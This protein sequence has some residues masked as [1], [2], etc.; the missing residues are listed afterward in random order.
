MNRPAYT[1][2]ANVQELLQQ[3]KP[4]QT[5]VVTAGMPYANGPLHL[6]HLA[7]AHVPADILARYMRMMIGKENV[8]YVCGT[9]DHGSTSEVAALKN[10][11]TVRE[12][13]DSIHT[14]QKATMDRYGISLN[15]YSGTSRPEWFPVHSELCQEFI[16]KLYHNGMLEKKR[17]NQ[18][19]NESEKPASKAGFFNAQIP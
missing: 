13:I 19:S 7:G 17:I 16:R 8:L 9:D 15:V 5:V 12:F 10:N 4:P 11:Q 6:G 2:P 18:T 3:L 14:K 1:P